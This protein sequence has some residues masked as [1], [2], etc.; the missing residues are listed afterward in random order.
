MAFGAGIGGLLQIFLR[1]GQLLHSFR[2]L[3]E[4]LGVTSQPFDEG[5]DARDKQSR[6]G[7]H[8][9]HRTQQGL[10]GCT[11]RRSRGR[12]Q[13]GCNR[14]KGQ[15]GGHA[16]ECKGLCGDNAGAG[17]LCHDL[18][19]RGGFT[20][21]RY[22]SRP[23]FR[24]RFL[25]QRR[26]EQFVR[27]IRS[28]S[29]CRG[30]F[31]LA[32]K[33]LH[34]FVA[35]IGKHEAGH[36][37][38]K[39]V[40]IFN[41]RRKHCGHRLQSFFKQ[42]AE[43]FDGV[44]HRGPVQCLLRI[45]NR[46]DNGLDAARNRSAHIIESGAPACSG[47][48]GRAGQGRE[49]GCTGGHGQVHRVDEVHGRELAVA[50]DLRNIRSGDADG[51]RI[52]LDGRDAGVQ[53]HLHVLHGDVA[54]RLHLTE[55]V[56][57]GAESGVGAVAVERHGIAPGPHG[58]G[59]FGY[60]H[61]TRREILNG[62]R[63]IVKSV[64]RAGHDLRG[65]R[66]RLIRGGNVAGHGRHNAGELLHGVDTAHGLVYRIGDHLEPFFQEF[67]DPQAGYKVVEFV[68]PGLKTVGVQFGIKNQ[69]AVICH[70][71][72]RFLPA[73]LFHF[74]VYLFRAPPHPFLH[75][76]LHRPGTA[77]FRRDQ[78][79]E[80]PMVFLLLHGFFHCTVLDL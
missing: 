60:L 40:H 66:Q 38:G 29:S 78:R 63:R 16:A 74:A 68:S 24:Q 7:D 22:G 41:D 34:D 2:L 51:V 8:K 67:E 72:V 10:D 23:R 48:F 36:G 14:G 28:C 25:I 45:I 5:S 18:F 4:R 37:D 1:T 39:D 47:L 19:F 15:P 32:G 44:A 11:Q 30:K 26:Y 42:A 59:R 12:E 77:L 73:C 35:S 20:Q 50:H 65:L 49:P 55:R 13:S 43:G 61:T 17:H 46:Q 58:L 33:R 9:S 56:R 52:H 75:I 53:Q 71:S 69:C 70:L 31:L 76:P 62:P 27:H 6:G 3:L 64:G 57:D 79:F 54:L 21:F 80:L